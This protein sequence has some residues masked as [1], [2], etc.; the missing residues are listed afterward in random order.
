MQ[1]W[2]FCIRCF[3]LDINWFK[4]GKTFVTTP[5]TTVLLQICLHISWFLQSW[6]L[7]LLTNLI[8]IRYKSII[9]CKLNILSVSSKYW[10]LSFFS[11]SN[12]K[13]VGCIHAILFGI[14]FQ[15]GGA[16]GVWGDKFR[17]KSAKKIFFFFGNQGQISFLE[18]KVIMVHWAKMDL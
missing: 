9:R 16:E 6:L 14:R 8:K 4:N 5:T 10:Y 12:N 3:V 1:T 2:L 13:K 7:F 17:G 11:Q 18:S 15:E